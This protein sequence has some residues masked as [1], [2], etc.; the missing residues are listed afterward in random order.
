MQ[1]QLPRHEEH[2]EKHKLRALRVFVV[3]FYTII[4]RNTDVA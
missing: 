2:E 4:S 1:E 3:F